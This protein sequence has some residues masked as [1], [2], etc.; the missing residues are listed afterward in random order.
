MQIL[1]IE[2]VRKV[3]DRRVVLDDISLGV[4]PGTLLGLLG[5]G[6]AGK[7]ML[8]RIVSGLTMPDAGDVYVG[9]ISLYRDFEQCMRYIGC[10]HEQPAFYT[11]R[12]G[13]ENLRIIAATR[14]GITKERLFDVADMLNLGNWINARVETYPAGVRKQ[15]AIAAAIMHNPRILLLDEATDGLDPVEFLSLRKLLKRMARE[16]G[17][18]VVMTSHQMTEIE[19][20]CD[21]VAFMQGGRLI[22]SSSVERLQKFGTGKICQRMKVDRPD[23][24]AR[25][26]AE[27]LEVHC[28]VR[29][30]YIVFD[31]DQALV[32]K[33]NAMLFTAGYM[34]YEFK[35]HQITLEEAYYRL[36]KE[37][38]RS[39]QG[40]WSLEY[41]ISPYERGSSDD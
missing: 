40:G 37:R 9:G 22:G 32:P 21:R 38:A 3:I 19:R 1:A 26:I 2:S 6:G 15:L 4:E 17:T 8:L 35:P 34:V 25:Y 5:P 30:G 31:C 39:G 16:F 27:A 13:L 33:I 36:L 20:T 11:R 18:A 12:S 10:V 28:E 41:D 7:S 24:A 23:A 14:G 29:N